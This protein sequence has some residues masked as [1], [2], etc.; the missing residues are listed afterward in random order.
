M[1]NF[2]K[3][4]IYKRYNI[5]FS[6]SGDD[7]HLMK[8]IGENTPG[9]YVDIGSWNPVKTSN[10]YYFYLRNWKGICIDPNP[11]LRELYRKHRNRDT[12]L[13]NGIGDPGEVKKY[14]MLNDPY[15]SLNTF[16][17]DFLRRN[18]VE[19]HIKDTKDIPLTSLEVVLDKHLKSTDRLDF[20]DVDVEGYDLEALK[21]NNWDKYRPKVILVETNSPLRM[22]INS[23][24]AEYLGDQEYELVGKSVI[25]GDLGN[26]FFRRNG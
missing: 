16:S 8:L 20:F 23:E 21:T 17:F 5:S 19:S 14:F 13:N 18:K 25:S 26:L 12:F 6:K 2:L 15:S 4:R 24:I 3:E 11:E 1:T 22:D 7:V 10:T 9:A